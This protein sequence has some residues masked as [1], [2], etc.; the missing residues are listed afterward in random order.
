MSLLT[1]DNK[2]PIYVNTSFAATTSSEI[3][4]DYP[5]DS[6]AGDLIIAHITAENRILPNVPSGWTTVYANTITNSE[7]PGSARLLISNIRN[8]ERSVTISVSGGG[9]VI[10]T[11]LR[12][13][14]N[15]I[16]PNTEF[17]FGNT[18]NGTT[19]NYT[20]ANT[21]QMFIIMVNNDGGNTPSPTINISTSVGA[22]AAT[23]NLT[24]FY[25]NSSPYKAMSMAYAN[26]IATSNTANVY[27]SKDSA[28]GVYFYVTAT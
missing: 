28:Y 25:N 13:F 7:G 1:S 19:F 2:T 21:R 22:P 5:I 27:I 20:I 8:D 18:S 3:T 12:N 6:R 23:G 11:A 14:Q 24:W 15:N 9:S 17:A 10:C 16:N 26:N 4:F